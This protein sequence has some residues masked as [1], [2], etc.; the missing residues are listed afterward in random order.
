MIQLGIFYELLKDW[1]PELDLDELECILAKLIYSGLV[2][3]YI[4]H[5]KRVIVLAS[6]YDPFPIKQ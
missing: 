4:N 2:R 3:G 1:D 6:K 5:D